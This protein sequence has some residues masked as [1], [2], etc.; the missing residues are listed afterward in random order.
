MKAYTVDTLW[1][2]M[3]RK[4]LSRA[5]QIA[6]CWY[7]HPV[8]YRSSCVWCKHI[9][10]FEFQVEHNKP[11]IVSGLYHSFLTPSLALWATLL[12]SCIP[13]LVRGRTSCALIV[14][15]WS[16]TA[17][18]SI[19]SSQKTGRDRIFI[20][21]LTRSRNFRVSQSPAIGRGFRITRGAYLYTTKQWRTSPWV[22][23]YLTILWERE[24][25]LSFSWYALLPLCMYSNVTQEPLHDLFDVIIDACR[26]GFMRAMF[27]HRPMSAGFFYGNGYWINL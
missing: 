27:V 3:I 8:R 14:C 1:T 24:R 19:S 11:W 23:P 18:Q 12:I 5:V 4:I 21:S 25:L 2:T 13:I 7:G 17:F 22:I 6:A 15:W 9:K 20:D 10:V 16:S 26:R